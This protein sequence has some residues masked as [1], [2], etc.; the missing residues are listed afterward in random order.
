MENYNN[1]SKKE[2]G[3]LSTTTIYLFHLI[4]EFGKLHKLTE[5]VILCLLHDQ[6]Q[7]TETDTCL[8]VSTFTQR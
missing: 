1:L 6:I 4:N 3:N 5:E 8:F 7:E 2:I